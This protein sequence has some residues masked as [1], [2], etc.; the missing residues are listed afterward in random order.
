IDLLTARQD[1]PPS[2]DA[3]VISQDGRHVEW[4][5]E[6]KGFRQLWVTETGR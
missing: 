3:V 6:L 2:S 5:E 4:M 1:N